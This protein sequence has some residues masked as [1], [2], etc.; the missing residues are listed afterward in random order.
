MVLE[1]SNIFIISRIILIGGSRRDIQ[2]RHG[3]SVQPF[4]YFGMAICEREATGAIVI[5]AW[6]IIKPIQ[7]G[8]VWREALHFRSEISDI[9]AVGA[10]VQEDK[11]LSWSRD[12]QKVTHL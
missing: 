1:P 8:R 11:N 7:A 12:R 4:L 5:K 10:H 9:D 3:A 6:Q 2:C